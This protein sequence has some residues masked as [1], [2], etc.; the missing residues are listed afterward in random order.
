MRFISVSQKK[1]LNDRRTI[2]QIE[3]KEIHPTAT[4]SIKY[5]GE[6]RS[7]KHC[8]VERTSD[9]RTLTWKGHACIEQLLSPPLCRLSFVVIPRISSSR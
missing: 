1:S 8:S 5:C 3:I 7:F 2:G 6:P 9:S 4:L